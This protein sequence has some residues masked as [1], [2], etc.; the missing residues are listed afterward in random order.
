MMFIWIVSFTFADKDKTPY[1]FYLNVDLFVVRIT[2]WL[3]CIESE[4]AKKSIDIVDKIT[5]EF[6]V[7]LWPDSPGNLPAAGKK[8]N[9]TVF[10]WNDIRRGYTHTAETY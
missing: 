6:M 4:D 2:C 1:P 3:T 8:R 10:E 7:M 9:N 5:Y